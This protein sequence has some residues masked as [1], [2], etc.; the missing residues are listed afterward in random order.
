MTD[1]DP[2]P[3]DWLVDFQRRFGDV[4]RAPLDR[5]RRIVEARTR[6]YPAALVAT[7]AQPKNTSNRARLAVYNRQYWFRLFGA[8]QGA[9]PLLDALVGSWR[10][11]A[12]V[13]HHLT[14]HPP[15]SFDL[16]A[17]ADGFAAQAADAFRATEACGSDVP[18]RE[19]VTVADVTAAACVDE[20]FRNAARARTA[21]PFRRGGPLNGAGL[22]AA[23]VRFAPSV[24]LVEEERA[25]VALRIQLDR[26]LTKSSAPDPA[27]ARQVVHACPDPH[28]QPRFWLVWRG[29]A[30]LTARPVDDAFG[31]FLQ[32]L[33][34]ATIGE[35]LGAAEDQ[36]T[37][38][39]HDATVAAQRW[40]QYC[41]DEGVWE[42]LEA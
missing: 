6:E 4:L 30:G 14:G 13:E 10:L 11:N 16:G 28:P 19:T 24:T 21:A 20:A 42:G 8:M 31:G 38:E 5:Q 23:R 17:V 3:P 1:F 35:A 37:R 9:F 39:G 25:W 18:W 33:R 22:A 32:R 2:S 29:P 40:F 34:D 7:V 27:F 41:V 12:M 26:A 15:T 36:L